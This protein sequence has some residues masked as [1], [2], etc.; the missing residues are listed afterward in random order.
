MFNKLIECVPNFSEGRNHLTINAIADAI[1]ATAG[2]TLLDVDAGASTN[3][4]VYSFV[5]SPTAVV[6]GA[7]NAAKVAYKL[8][9]MTTHKGE[10]KRLGAMDVCPF[11]PVSSGATMDDCVEAANQLAARLAEL[12]VPVYLYG[13]AARADYRRQVP[14]IRAGEYEILETRLKDA[15]W[16][17]DYG[18][19]K[20][21]PRWGASIVGARNFLIAYNVNLVSTKEQAHRIALIIRAVRSNGEPGRL[22]ATQAM[23]WY[24]KEANI[25][26]VT[27]NILD[28]ELTK[29]HQVYEEVTKEAINLKL[30]VTG[31]E[32]VGLVPLKAMLDVAEHYIQKENLFILDE[33]QKIHLA[34]NRLGLN[35]LGL[36][37][38]KKRIIEYMIAKPETDK[39]VELSLATFIR[40]VGDRTTAPGGG[41]VAAT[42]GALGVA[43][44]AMV[45][46][47]AYGK[48]I[49]EANDATMRK[50]IPP[51][52]LAV[53]ELGLY[54][55]EDT[56]AFNDYTEAMKLP[57]GD[58]QQIKR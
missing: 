57:E 44:A 37:D 38:P 16:Q 28:I 54:I 50:L 22:P 10:H 6:E 24:L 40:S 39:L 34:I 49:F 12:G 4:T 27:V 1:R 2:V 58:E 17:P 5:G 55:D 53:T 18:P 51:L 29:L 31:S 42:V 26:Q 33:D 25:A 23:G 8:I 13:H 43:L 7:L 19:A 30:P 47:L 35:S 56:Q 11:I 41:S 46:K 32:I 48:K 9:D 45:G 36:F 21:V 15:A 52:H 20:F 3:R 14:Q